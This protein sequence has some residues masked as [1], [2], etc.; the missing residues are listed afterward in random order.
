MLPRTH[1]LT[2]KNANHLASQPANSAD[3]IRPEPP[4]LDPD[5]AGSR[6]SMSSSGGG[7]GGRRTDRPADPQGLRHLP[8]GFLAGCDSFGCLGFIFCPGA[9]GCRRQPTS[10]DRPRYRRQ[11]GTPEARSV[12]A[13]RLTAIW[14]LPTFPKVPEYWRATPGEASPSLANPVSSI[15]HA[16]GPIRSINRAARRRRTPRNPRSRTS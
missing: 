9:D 3:R 14:Q 16:T 10:Q 5:Q 6:R 13:C 4:G 7:F 15:T 2:W 1:A 11:P 8:A 12:A